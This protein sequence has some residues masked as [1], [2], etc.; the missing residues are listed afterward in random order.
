VVAHLANFGLITKA[1]E[2]I[3]DVNVL[4]LKVSRSKNGKLVWQRSNTVEK[5]TR[6]VTRF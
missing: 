2:K 1:R 6:E 5:P 3:D 4:G